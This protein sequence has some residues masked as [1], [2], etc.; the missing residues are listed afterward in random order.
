MSSP[1]WAAVAVLRRP[2]PRG[3][4]L[5]LVQRAARAGDPWSGD[6]AFP[7]GWSRPEDA[8]P[9]ATARREC[10]EEVGIALVGPGAPEPPL[11]AFDPR[12]GRPARLHPVR[13][14]VPAGTAA[15]PD[16]GEVALARWV[17]EAALRAP[18]RRRWLL[19]RGRVPW[20]APVLEVEGLR[21][22]GLTLTVIGRLGGGGAGAGGT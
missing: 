1:R 16:P 11:W 4:E 13:F 6:V 17:P 21:V 15:R 2:G 19:V 9:T 10:A 20:W 3:P 8:D 14:E 7:G 22:W 18:A 5:L 12:R